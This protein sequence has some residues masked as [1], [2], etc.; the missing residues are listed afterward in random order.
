MDEQHER[1]HSLSLGYVE[2]MYAQYLADPQSVSEQWRGYFAQ[3]SQENGAL[4]EV[5]LGPSFRAAS[6]FNPPTAS[7]NGSENGQAHSNGGSAATLSADGAMATSGSLAFEQATL[8]GRVDQMVRAYR[9]RGHML[10]QLDPLERPRKAVR[11]LDPAFYGLTEAHMDRKFAMPPLVD[12]PT[13]TLREILEILRQTYCRSIGVQYMHIHDYEPKIWLL[14]RM[15][16][17]QNRLALSREQQLRILTKLTEA[18]VFEDFFDKKYLGVKRFSLQGSESLIPLLQSVLDT[19]AEHDIKGAVLGMAHRGRLNV[20]AH[21]FGIPPR[22]IFREFEGTN[23]LYEEKHGDVKYHLG[24]STFWK[25]QHGK[26]LYLSMCFNPSHLEFI[27]PVVL[28]RVRAEQDRFND[29]QRQHGLAI[30]IHGDAAFTGEGISQETLNLSELKGYQVGGALHI[31]TNNQVGFTTDPDDARSMTYAADVAKMLQVPVFHVNGEDPEAVTQVVKLAMDFRREFK[32]DVVI[33]MYGYR[34]WGH[35][36]GDEPSFTQPLMYKVIKSRKN[37]RE[38]YL[39]HLLQLGGV[40]REEADGI[41]TKVRALLDEELITTREQGKAIVS[42]DR[43]G[44][45]WQGYTGGREEHVEEVNTGYDKGR[46]SEILLQLSQVPEGFTP[47]PTLQKFLLANRAAMSRGEKP[48]DWGAGE[49]LA[50]ATLAL[51]GHRIRITGQ[52]AERGT[53]AHRHSVL[54]DNQNGNEYMALAHLAPDQAPVEIYNSPLSENAVMGFEFGY[55]LDCPSGLIAWEAQ[56]GDFY[57]AAQVYIDQFIASAEDKWSYLSGLTLLLPHGCEGMGP[58][59]SSARLE[60]FLQMC[61]DDNMQVCAP[62]TPAQIFHLLRRQVLRP[63]RKPLIVLTPKGFLRLAEA[64][65]SLDELATGRFQRILG[66]STVDPQK[67]SKVLFCFGKVYYELARARAEAGREDIAILRLEQFYPLPEQELR[68]AFSAFK[69]GTP[70][71]WVQEEPE[72]MGAWHYLK[73]RFGSELPGG[74]PLSVLSRPAAS[75]PSTGSAKI[76]EK[77]QKALIERAITA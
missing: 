53:F 54:H 77:T 70:V 42:T 64:S 25:N 34:F 59:H 72:N 74:Y 12:K 68:K 50:L 32:R 29:P 37:V 24:Y 43:T 6:L 22:E 14:E 49:G 27:N 66:D 65:S 26:E 56:F 23:P 67:V 61:A 51:E 69:A 39:D 2:E 33:D 60:R 36:E 10:A 18:V 28:G 15:E 47:H 9:V 58:E 76:H 35:N 40:T 71:T 38:G 48:L 11:E 19:A 8:Q 62:T 13:L 57:N 45:L 5:Q 7:G 31:I 75:S 63:W 21:I 41:A 30:L 46:L 16:G 52:D 73:L 44:S 3:I 20:L 17:T 4:A 55:S 1:M